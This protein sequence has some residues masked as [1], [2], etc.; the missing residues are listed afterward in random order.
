V[1][2]GRDGSPAH[3]PPPFIPQDALVQRLLGY[4]VPSVGS[5]EP[6]LPGL[7]PLSQG[8]YASQ[9]RCVSVLN[10]ALAALDVSSPLFTVRGCVDVCVLCVWCMEVCA[11]P[12]ISSPFH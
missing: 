3:A 7:D 4:F 8:A 2:G 1:G 9:F 6:T 10:A 12:P 11:C 5:P